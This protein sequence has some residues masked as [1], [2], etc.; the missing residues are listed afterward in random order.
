VD[1]AD[2]DEEAVAARRDGLD[3]RAFVGLAEEAP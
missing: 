3:E 2:R 1:D